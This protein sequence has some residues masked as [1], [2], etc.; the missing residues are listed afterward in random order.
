MVTSAVLAWPS[1]RLRR[2]VLVTTVHNEFAKSAVLMGLGDRVIAVSAAVHESMTR[3]GIPRR[4]LRTVLNGT[5][6]CARQDTPPPEG[7]ELDH[8][9]VAFVGGLHPR[10]GVADLI[11]AFD[12]C[13]AT[14][15]EAHL[16]IVGEGP[17]AEAYSRQAAACSS[18]SN[19]TF[20][21]AL[22]DPRGVL[23]RADV[24]V[25]PSLS[26]PAPLV[27]PEAREAQCAIIASAVDG[28]P[29]LLDYGEAGVLTPPAAPKE[30]ARALERM[31]SSPATLEEWKLR[32]ERDLDRFSVDRVAR[33]AIDI[34]REALE[35]H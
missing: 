1:T 22:E 33:D 7:P 18:A 10:K 25:L 17:Y 31:L 12:L 23:R 28:I 35:A 11:A 3:R 4:K 9:A 29:E 5:I 27:I 6:G 20:C 24:F 2:I 8:P 13:R 30:L 34:Y 19:I 21:G 26:D 14:I 15:P 16:Y 32:A